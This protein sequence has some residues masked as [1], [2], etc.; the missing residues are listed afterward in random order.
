L[1]CEIVFIERRAE[2]WPALITVVM[3][4]LVGVEQGILFAIA[5]SLIDR[6]SSCCLCA[7]CGVHCEDKI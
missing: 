6:V 3:V 1:K 5:L 4:V 2:F 7:V